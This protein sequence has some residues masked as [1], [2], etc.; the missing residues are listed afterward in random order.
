VLRKA[1]DL[2]GTAVD[3]REQLIA[4]TVRQMNIFYFG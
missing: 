4:A 1:A 2:I 3:V